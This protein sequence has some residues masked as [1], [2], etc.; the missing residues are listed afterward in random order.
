[1]AE[2]QAENFQKT[3]NDGLTLLVTHQSDNI[4]QY[5]RRC[6]VKIA[7]YTFITE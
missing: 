6:N 4:W 5:S 3:I 2:N 7:V 1:M